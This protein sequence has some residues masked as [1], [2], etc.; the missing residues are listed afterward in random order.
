MKFNVSG[1]RVIPYGPMPD[2]LDRAV[3]QIVQAA[4]EGQQHL[5]KIDSPV[6]DSLEVV[7]VS[8]AEWA[9]LRDEV[10]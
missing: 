3:D 10:Q 8:R 1:V 6:R 2:E 5:Q 9:M 7:L 4:L